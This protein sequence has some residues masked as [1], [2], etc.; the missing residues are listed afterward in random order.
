MAL[1]KL[2]KSQWWQFC[3]R[4]SQGLEGQ[5][6]DIEIASP[7]EGVQPDARWL[8]AADLTCN[9]GEG[10]L[11]IVRENVGNLTF[12]PREL[13]IDCRERGLESLCILDQD[14]LWHIVLLRDPLMLPPLSCAETH[15]AVNAPVPSPSMARSLR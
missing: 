3:N 11:D 15:C 4:V 9:P 1:H 2:D 8:P 13:Y 6:M 7:D 5:P 10:V 12:R 14:N